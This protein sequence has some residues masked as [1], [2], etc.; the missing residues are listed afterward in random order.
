MLKHTVTIGLLLFMGFVLAVPMLHIDCD[1]P[2][3]QDDKITCC[4]VKQEKSQEKT[5][6]IDMKS[7][8]MGV[9][10]IPII[11]GPF[12]KDNL[13]FELN[14][15]NFGEDNSFIPPIENNCNLVLFDHP[16]EPP[17]VFNLPLL[18]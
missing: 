5:C 18:L 6:R 3:C 4:E 2:C 14:I 16:T 8:D 17:P 10:F 11:A 1:M 12:Q 13:N 15:H 9:V 7:C